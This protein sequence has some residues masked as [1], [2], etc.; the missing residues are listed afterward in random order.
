MQRKTLLVTFV[1]V[2]IVVSALFFFLLQHK[3]P[4][5]TF[6]QPQQG[7]PQTPMMSK[8]K[9][10]IVATI[11]SGEGGSVLVNG[12]ATPIWSSTSP[13]SLRLEAVP[14]EC[15]A[16]DYWEVNGSRVG[17]GNL[18]LVIAGNT[19]IR[20]VFKRPIYTL[21]LDSNV[22]GAQIEVNGTIVK[23]PF[24]KE[25]PCGATV[26]VAM[27]PLSNETTSYTPSGFLVNNENVSSSELE[28]HIHGN[29]TI[30][31][32]YRAE[33]HVLYIETNAP[34]IKVL[35]DGQEVTLPARIQRPSPFTVTIQA[36]PLIKVN[37][38][39]AWGSP[40][41]QEQ[42]Y[43]RGMLTWITFAAG[44]TSI[45]VE[46]AE[47]RIRVYY[48]PLYSPSGG[49]IYVTSI[50][51]KAYVEGNTIIATPDPYSV[52]TVDIILPPNWTRVR[53]R[54]ESS[55]ALGTVI[56]FPYNINGN[57]DDEVDASVDAQRGACGSLVA[58]F[59][60]VRNPP[61]I[62]VLSYYCNAPVA[63]SHDYT[64]GPWNFGQ[65]NEQYLGRL[66]VVTGVGSNIR[67]H[68]EVEG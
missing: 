3:T 26:N 27:L 10:E 36:P 49:G 19:T 30:Q 50:F 24:T 35:V 65:G 39:F 47:K 66:I 46:E 43:I 4:S 52:Y 12:T 57:I 48:Y 41:I 9:P 16:L 62:R 31:A 64:Q 54:V 51:G 22:D 55:N 33:T 17:G 18:T 37:D 42:G 40:E 15:Y 25:F 21:S 53:V 23:A 2:A 63:P 6:I 1:I 13:F 28:L 44:N 67:I 20:A 59:E 5:L 7:A 45:H 58:E 68:V 11:Q 56:M 60:V 8:P 29:L 61:S 32:I 34:G 14:K 38:T